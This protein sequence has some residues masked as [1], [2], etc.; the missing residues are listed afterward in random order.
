VSN[1]TILSL[2]LPGSRKLLSVTNT[3]F[4]RL[5]RCLAI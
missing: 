4:F 5:L 3:G 2:K 1:V